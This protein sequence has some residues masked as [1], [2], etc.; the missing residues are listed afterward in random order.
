[1]TYFEELKAR[2]EE[3]H[4]EHKAERDEKRAER[5]ER[6]AFDVAERED[7]HELKEETKADSHEAERLE[8]DED[9]KDKAIWARP[10]R[11]RNAQMKIVKNCTTDSA[12]MK[13]QQTTSLNDLQ[14]E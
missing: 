1:M 3:H 7:R 4:E 13:S 8:R 2:C 14:R 5:D 10:Q 9:R 12:L 6:H 11:P